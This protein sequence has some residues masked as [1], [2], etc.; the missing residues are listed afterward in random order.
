MVKKLQFIKLAGVWFVHIPDY[1]G[2]PG[3]L[4]MVE[5]ADVLCDILDTNDIGYISAY[6]STEPMSP[7]F[8][9]YSDYT[10]DFINTT[11]DFGANYKLREFK[12][13]VWLCNVVT[14]LF[15]EFPVT[16]YIRI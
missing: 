11:E 6:V 5:G 3:D 4:A 10:L 9:K 1:P 2:D 14:Y 13:D 12:L 16:F 7:E 8:S 15:G